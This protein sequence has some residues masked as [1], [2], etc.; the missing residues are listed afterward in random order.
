[1]YD[2]ILVPLDGSIRAERILP[3]VEHLALTER[4]RVIFLRVVKPIFVTDGF[5]TVA[6][7]ESMVENKNRLAEA[8]EYLQKIAGEFG[9][10][11]IEAEHLA[12]T[13]SVVDVIIRTAQDKDVDLVA[14]A[15]HGRGG[16]SRVFYG[17]VAAGVL[18]KVDRPLF[19]IRSQW[20]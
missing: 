14:M 1:M 7:D 20:D 10:K 8:D 16:L 4:A 9:E 3:H 6:V 2:K 12:E 19:L 17:S 18:H 11:H 13:G 15:S 5:Q